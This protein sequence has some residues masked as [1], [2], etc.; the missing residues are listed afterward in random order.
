MRRHTLLHQAFVAILALSECTYGFV[1][2]TLCNHVEKI[3]RPTPSTRCYTSSGFSESSV[4]ER[5][6]GQD[7]TEENKRT[8]Y[9][10]LGAERTDSREVLKQKY[11]SLAKICHPDAIMSRGKSEANEI[12][13]FTEIAAAWR[14]LSDKKQRKRYDRSLQAEEFSDNVLNWVGDMAVEVAPVVKSF[15]NAANSIFRKTTASTLAGVQA[16]A[17]Q[18]IK[19]T[20]SLADQPGPASNPL[21]EAFKSAAEAAR[22]AGRAVDGY[23]LMEK[24]ESLEARSSTELE[25]AIQAKEELQNVVEKRLRMSLHTP[26]SGLTAA[27]ASVILEDFT[28]TIPDDLSAWDLVTLRRTVEFE[29][30]QLQKE[31]MEFVAAQV[32][33]TKAQEF[34]QQ[35]VQ[36]RFKTKQDLT[37]AERAEENARL[38]YE[39]AKK[40]VLEAREAHA[41]SVQQLSQAETVSRKS[42]WEIEVRSVSMERQSEKVRQALKQKERQ[43]RKELGMDSS[44]VPD[45][46]GIRRLQELNDLREEERLKAEASNRMERM[47]ERLKARAQELRDR[48]EELE[49]Q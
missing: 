49:E 34:Y 31:E 44:A 10:V 46:G 4:G 13:D 23:E 35:S 45:R 6:S 1:F 3:Q 26:G 18:V 24:S 16:A 48:A 28:K 42:D 5:N 8:L 30:G 14:I 19:E 47:A 32:A 25:Q 38:A 7:A 11:T 12:P 40:R 33:D 17:T 43:V 21:S 39:N 15:G 36:E 2:Q 20:D 27:E 29:I 22:I 9:D 37:D 41:N